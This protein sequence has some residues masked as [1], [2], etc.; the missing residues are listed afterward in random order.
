MTKDLTTSAPS[1][2]MIK[3]VALQGESATWIS[4]GGNDFSSPS[5]TI[6]FV[7]NPHFVW[8]LTSF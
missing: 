6:M 3:V 8:R 7:V 5:T 4:K 1:A 2:M